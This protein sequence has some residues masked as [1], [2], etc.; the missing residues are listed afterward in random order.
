MG[1]GVV[2]A[3]HPQSNDA[4]DDDQDGDECDD[5]TNYSNYQRV[6][7]AHRLLDL[8]KFLVYFRR[9]SDGNAPDDVGLGGGRSGED[10]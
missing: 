6:V 2:W 10:S 8:R 1:V 3:S 7:V 5:S 4:N 9:L